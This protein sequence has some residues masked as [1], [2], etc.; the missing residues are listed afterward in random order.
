MSISTTH[1]WE[2]FP[3]PF[4]FLVHA[5]QSE[6]YTFIFEKGMGAFS[7]KAENFWK[8]AEVVVTNPPFSAVRS[9]FTKILKYNCP[10][11]LL[12]PL[13]VLTSL[14]FRKLFAGR[15][16]DVAIKVCRPLKFFDSN[17]NVTKATLQ[18]CFF[19]FK[20]PRVRKFEVYSHYSSL[21]QR[22]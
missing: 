4:N 11:I 15:M 14:Y 6:G 20:I 2:P 7:R 9:I 18:V 16:N 8:N 17:L 21:L 3:G 13:G 10:A 19:G 1:F 5:L 12:M 22:N